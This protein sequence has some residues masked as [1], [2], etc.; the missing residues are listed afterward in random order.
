M[1]I[2]V[3]ALVIVCILSGATNILAVEGLECQDVISGIERHASRYGVPATL[4]VDS[5]TQ[6]KALKH[7]SCSVW[8]IEAQI[9]DSLGIRIVVSNA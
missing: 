5:G 3:Y 6:L 2:K 8:D 1:G 7:A 4:F 9:Q